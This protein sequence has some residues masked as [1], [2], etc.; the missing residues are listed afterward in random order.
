MIKMASRRKATTLVA[1]V[2]VIVSVLAIGLIAF[3]YSGKKT[4]KIENNSSPIAIATSSRTST[5]VASATGQVAG[6]QSYVVQSGDTLFAISA[7]Y[8][9]KLDILAAYNNLSDPYPIKIG[10]VIKIPPLDGSYKGNGTKTFNQDLDQLKQ[11]QTSVDEGHQPWRLDPVQTAQAEVPT[12]F[13]ITNYDEFKLI[14]KDLQKGEAKIN[15]VHDKITYEILMVQPIR[16]GDS[17]IWAT[18]QVTKK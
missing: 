18:K 4:A 14:S 9:V 12:T 7:K 11:I 6:E 1:S 3:S 13:S 16:K 5:P 17:G 15:V 2:A 10:Q 8:N